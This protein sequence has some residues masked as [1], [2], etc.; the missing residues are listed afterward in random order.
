MWY[1]AIK[2]YLILF[3]TK[4]E[5]WSTDAERWSTIRVIIKN[6]SRLQTNISVTV[7]SHIWLF[8][9]SWTV[10]LQ[11]PLSMGFSQQEHWSG[12]PVPP[13]GDLPNPRIK[14]MSPA[15]SPALAGGFFTTEPPGNPT[16]VVF[17]H[18]KIKGKI[19]EFLKYLVNVFNHV[20]NFVTFIHHIINVGQWWLWIWHSVCNAGDLGSIPGSGRSPGEENDYQSQ[21]SYLENSMD[22]GAWWL[23][24]Y[25]ITESDMNE[26]L[27]LSSFFSP[28]IY[29]SR[30]L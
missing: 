7:L 25:G 2:G 23:I 27:I 19:C 29:R 20:S 13:P 30:F 8:A 17:K 24:V 21:Y 3:Y 14:S 15:S 4:S 28:L 10:A 12:L 9:T 11:A 26:Q 16:V 6:S 5:E 1:A 22:R 18:K